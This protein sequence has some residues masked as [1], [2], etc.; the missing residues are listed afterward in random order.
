MFA[1]EIGHVYHRKKEMAQAKPFMKVAT[2][3][4]VKHG[5]K[6]L[7]YSGEIS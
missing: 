2:C 4:P 6:V 1:R 3:L 7:Y 5:S